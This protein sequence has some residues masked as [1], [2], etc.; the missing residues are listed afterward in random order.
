MEVTNQLDAAPP[1]VV[2]ETRLEGLI[3]NPFNQ[4]AYT[5]GARQISTITIIGGDP[6]PTFC[7]RGPHRVFECPNWTALKAFQA[8][9]ANNLEPNEE[10]IEMDTPIEEDEKNLRMGPL[11]SCLHY[12]R[13]QREAK[14]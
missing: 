13:K 9:L 12:R 7:A 11:S 8:S 1:R 4:G 14:N 3:V 6:S 10:T 5:K 2:G